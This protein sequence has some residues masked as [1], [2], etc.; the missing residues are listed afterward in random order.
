MPITNVGAQPVCVASVGDGP[1]TVF[2]RDNVNALFWGRTQ[3]EAVKANASIID[4]QTGLQTDGS[5][6]IF[7]AS[8]SAT[9]VMVDFIPAGLSRVSSNISVANGNVTIDNATLDVIGQGGFILPG[10]L[11]L[12]FDN[13]APVVAA[14]LSSQARGP[15]IVNN[16]SSIMFTAN[17]P[18]SSSVAAGAAVCAVWNF[19]WSDQSGN[20]ISTTDTI[21]CFM[22]CDITVQ[23]P[24]KGYQVEIFLNNIGTVG[25]ITYANNDVMLW[26]D[27]RA[28]DDI[29]VLDTGQ[30]APTITGWNVFTQPNPVY[31]VSQWLASVID[32]VQ[33]ASKFTLWPMPQFRGSVSGMYGQ[34]TEALARFATIVDMT[35]AVQGSIVAGTSYSF[36]IL[37][38]MNSAAGTTAPVNYNSPPTQLAFIYETGATAGGQTT[39]NL[40]GV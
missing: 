23:I 7:V 16:Y 8:M 40:T 10:E 38:S 18:S 12:L 3:S 29:V 32:S 37:Q 22:D 15:F 24:V 33:V 2:N 34:S 9:S 25:T 5:V 17:G 35:Y 14:P 6:D 21:S 28:V 26:G 1:G 36:G 13:T 11:Q 20:I 19:Q 27:Y 4:A 30:S 39:L 31:A